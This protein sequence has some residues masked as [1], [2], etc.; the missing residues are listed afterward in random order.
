MPTPVGSSPLVSGL[1]KGIWQ[2]FSSIAC[3]GFAAEI[4]YKLAMDDG[5]RLLQ[6]VCKHLGT[7]LLLT[8]IFTAAALSLLVEHAEGVFHKVL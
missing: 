5:L 8:C 2:G 7:L 1:E 4:T 3:W 6:L